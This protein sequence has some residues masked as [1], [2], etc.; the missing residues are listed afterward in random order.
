MA[1]VDKLNVT[2]V[3][4]DFDRRDLELA[5]SDVFRSV[6]NKRYKILFER[7]APLTEKEVADIFA[8][9]RIR[10]TERSGQNGKS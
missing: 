8:R 4:E 1:E 2:L 7:I 10:K 6:I 9:A 5:F 3:V